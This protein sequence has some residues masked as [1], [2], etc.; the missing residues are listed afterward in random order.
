[1]D[2]ESVAEVIVEGSK[3]CGNSS[4]NEKTEDI[5]VKKK[6]ELLLPMNSIVRNKEQVLPTSQKLT[7]MMP[8]QAVSQRRG[9]KYLNHGKRIKGNV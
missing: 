8:C 4:S 3:D 5:L 6:M 1:M 2:A 9:S 7:M